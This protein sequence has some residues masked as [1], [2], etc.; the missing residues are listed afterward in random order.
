[1]AKVLVLHGPNLNLLGSRE[2][3]IYGSDSLSDINAR[4]VVIARE[5]GHEAVC[6]QFNGEGE[7]I[8]RL[9]HTR[10]DG[11]SFV[12]FNPAGYTHTSVALRDALL[13]VAIPF[14]EVHLSNPKTR[15]AFRHHSYFSDIAVGVISGFGAQSYELAVRAACA[16]LSR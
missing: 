12:V 1:M 15:E 3:G 5:L 2:P 16:R 8:N 7:L 14:I 4:C 10:H 13:S 6:D 9:H 11:T